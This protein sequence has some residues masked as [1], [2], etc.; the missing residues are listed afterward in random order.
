MPYVIVEK[1]LGEQYA[2]CVDVCPVE[3]IHPIDYEGKPF[4]IIDPE[5]CID[6]GVCLPEC[7]IGAIVASP[8]EDPAWAEINKNLA[9]QAKE[10]EAQHGKVTPR[11]PNDPPRRPDNKL[12]K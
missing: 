1:C 8:A 5:V 4:M 2:A 9:A 11:P 3:C 7:P 10:W 6:C 12:V